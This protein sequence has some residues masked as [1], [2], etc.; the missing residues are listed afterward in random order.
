MKKSLTADYADAVVSESRIHFRRLKSPTTA[1]TGC[2]QICINLRHP[3]MNFPSQSALIRWLSRQGR[4]RRRRVC[5]HSDPIAASAVY[6]RLSNPMLQSF[7]A[8]R[9]DRERVTQHALNQHRMVE[10]LRVYDPQERDTLAIR[11]C[12][13]RA[14]LGP[15]ALSQRW[16]LR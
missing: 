8:R 3:W 6:R 4:G 13:R 10:Y 1:S 14:L 12:D 16:Q 2:A 5:R 9:R 11:L 15:R 7:R